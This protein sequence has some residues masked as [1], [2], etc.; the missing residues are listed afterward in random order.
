MEQRSQ[1]CRK[2]FRQEGM[3]RFRRELEG[4]YSWR[5]L[6]RRACS[7][8][9]KRQSPRVSRQL[10]ALCSPVLRSAAANW[11][12]RCCFSRLRGL[13]RTHDLRSYTGSI[14]GVVTGRYRAYGYCHT[15]RFLSQL[16]RVQWVRSADHSSWLLDNPPVGSK[17]PGCWGGSFSLFVH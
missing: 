12:K 5:P 3:R 13:H 2:K 7:P 8:I 6:M 17:Q 4:Y 16:A 10:L 15:E 11:C 14:V 1:P 9:W